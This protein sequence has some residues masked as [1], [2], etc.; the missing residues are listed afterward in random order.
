[1]DHKYLTNEIIP[2]EIS[3]G[4]A[5]F[6][7]YENVFMPIMRVI[8]EDNLLLSFP[9][10]TRAELFLWVTRHWHF[11]KKEAKRDVSPDEAVYSYGAKFGIGGFNRF[12]YKLKMLAA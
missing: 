4:Q 11:L 7:W 3:M 12:L 2:F 8:D 10:A 1:M 5:I 9:G 6:S